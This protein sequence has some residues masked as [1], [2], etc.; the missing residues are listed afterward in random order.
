MNYYVKA[1]YAAVIAFLG[2]VLAVLQVP[3]AVGI[4]SA[5]WVAIALATILA[6]GGV[7]GLQS[8]PATVS[9]SVK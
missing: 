9:T 4:T 3:E 8:A 7:L 1:G 6:A 5:S 2:S